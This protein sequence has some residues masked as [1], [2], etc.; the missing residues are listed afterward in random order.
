MRFSIFHS[1]KQYHR[2]LL[3]CLMA[4]VVT[5]V[6]V[7]LPP[8][9]AAETQ[10]ITY[11]KSNAIFP[12]PER[13]WYFIQMPYGSVTR[14]LDDVD[15]DG[16]RQQNI[17]M[18]RQVYL[19]DKWHDQALP[20]SL[21]DTMQ[22]DFDLVSEN[23]FKIILKFSYNWVHSETGNQ[24]A[25]AARIAQ[26]LDQMKPLLEENEDVIAFLEESFVGYW[27]EW[28]DSTSGHVIPKTLTLTDE[29]RQAFKRVADYLPSRMWS[30]RYGQQLMQMY[31]I[32]LD[33]ED[34]FTGA[35]QARVGLFNA[36][37]RSDPS[38][39]GSWSTYDPELEAQEKA[40]AEQSTAYTI[41]SG[42]PGGIQD[43]VNEEYAKDRDGT[44]A[45][46]SR[47]HY[48]ALAVNQSDA[49]ATGQYDAWK[50]NG[51]YDVGDRR[52]GYRFRL[53]EA[54]LPDTATANE[55]LSVLV[56]MANDGWARP[57]NPR[58][59]EV[60]L[61][62]VETDAVIRLPVATD[63]DMRL[64]LPGPGETKDLSLSAT[65]PEDIASG[66]YEVLLNLPDPATTLN[67]RPE[68]SIRLANQDVWEAATGYNKLNATLTVG[69]TAAQPTPP[70]TYLPLVQ[71]LTLMDATTNQPIAGY[72]TLADGAT[73]DLADVTTAQVSL[74]ATT[75]PT[76]VGSVQFTC[77]DTVLQTENYQP[78]TSGGD[79][80]GGQDLLPMTLP[81]AGTHTCTV[82]PFTQAQAQG[83]SGTPLTFTLVV[84]A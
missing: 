8:A 17:T 72:E 25:S 65:L 69:S 50:Q 29:G 55:Q 3:L 76:Q 70:P 18:V 61:R 63:Q 60:V 59:L 40:F 9:K 15:F 22:A 51:A 77:D 48:S 42:E 27:G 6:V 37:F 73:V 83:E 31:E 84:P 19:L 20:Q 36:G 53:I 1:G 57:Y 74:V 28:H 81:A 2:I 11:A 47:F 82:T 14:P 62:H 68:Y 78:Y 79:Q 23:G 41:Q 33:P 39:F 46:W 64:F 49:E 16:L 75:A 12:N 10:T 32:P 54:T 24:D 66:D 43:P 67:D 30:S 71:Q 44:I 13:G 80:A 35:R 52:F 4:L 26:H 21:L 5:T 58:D 34:A 7:Q 38:D 56:Q 45:D